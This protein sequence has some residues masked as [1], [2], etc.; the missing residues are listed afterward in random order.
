MT[1]DLQNTNPVV[2]HECTPTLTVG[3]VVAKTYQINRVIGKGGMSV[4]YLADQRLLGR[5]FALKVLDVERKSESAVRRFIQEATT[6]AQLKHPNLVAVH[7][8]GLLNDGQP[9]LVMDFIDGPTLAQY[10]E[11]DGPMPIPNVVALICQLAFGLMYAHEK[12]VVHRDIKPGNIMLLKPHQQA[13][14]G[15]VKIVDFGIAK[16]TQSEDGEVQRLTR[17]GEI[18]G[19]PTYMSPEQCRGANVDQRSDIYSLGCVMFECLTGNPP[20]VGDSAM[21]TMVLRLTEKPKTLSEATNGNSFPPVLDSIIAKMLRT[22]PGERYQDVSA[23]ISDLMQ[24]QHGSPVSNLDAAN[25]GF[26]LSKSSK[27]SRQNRAKIQRRILLCLISAAVSTTGTLII[28]NILRSKDLAP[29]AVAP[30]AKSQPLP[31]IN[32]GAD[33]FEKG[34]SK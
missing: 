8:Y 29:K 5:A 19:S 17:T 9:Y 1:D 14:E 4:V 20:F 23:L 28:E 13:D 31:Q 27:T 26:I 6:A 12:G 30:A 33:E 25:D 24:L 18:F 2:Q 32:F 3:D 21:A 11:H 22:E 16:L 15:S 34:K 10:L 7:D